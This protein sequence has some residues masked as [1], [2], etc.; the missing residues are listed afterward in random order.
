MQVDD[1][2]APLDFVYVT[3]HVAGEKVVL[4][5]FGW[6][7]PTSKVSRYKTQNLNP[8]ITPVP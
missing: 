8:N 4:S 3:S 2:A 5:N 6:F 1:A 7:N